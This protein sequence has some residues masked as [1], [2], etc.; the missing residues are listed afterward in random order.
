M[1]QL[2]SHTN[3][4]QKNRKAPSKSTTLMP[5]TYNLYEYLRDWVWYIAAHRKVQF[6]LRLLNGK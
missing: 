6:L 5:E 1:R 2:P 4:R 3:T